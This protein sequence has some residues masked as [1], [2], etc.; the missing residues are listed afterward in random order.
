[1]G[2]SHFEMKVWMHLKA[3]VRLKKNPSPPNREWGILHH[4]FHLL[5]FQAEDKYQLFLHPNH[6][7][8]LGLKDLGPLMVEQPTP[9]TYM[10]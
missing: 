1:M 7:T 6:L 3:S 5:P 2:R 4:E 8:V 10:N 9:S